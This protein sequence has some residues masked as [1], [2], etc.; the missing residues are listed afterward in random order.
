[1]K[2]KILICLLLLVISAC[3]EE[4]EREK[5]AKLIIEKVEQFKTEKNRLP[6]NA[7]EIRLIELEDSKA[8]YE[9]KTDSTY[10]VW[11]GLSLG[12]SK[13]YYSTTKDWAEGGKKNKTSTQQIRI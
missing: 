9:K 8:F 6:K 10:I 5:Y 11:F 13:I 3:S 12:E 2:F 4:I 1:M 7:S